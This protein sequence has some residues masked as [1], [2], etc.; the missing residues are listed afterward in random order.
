VPEALADVVGGFLGLNDFRI[1]SSAKV[2]PPDY[3]TGSSH[4]LV[5]EDFAT[6]YNVTPLYAAGIDGTGQ[7]IAVVG[8]SDVALSDIRAFRTRYGLPANDPKMI[9]YTF[10]DPGFNGSQLEG[11]LDL[12]WAGAIAPKATINYV[13]GPN[14]LTAIVMAVEMNV[15]PVITS[16]YGTCEIN[17][18]RRPTARSRS[19]AMRRASRWWLLRAMVARPAATLKAPSRWQ[20]A[21]SLSSSQRRCPK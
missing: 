19:R 9:P 8:Q 12:E 1:L 5:P 14:A 6:I 13:Y 15:A 20:R 16:S 7:Q 18:A 21:A 11:N 3:D 17:A 2:V 4:Y 10:V